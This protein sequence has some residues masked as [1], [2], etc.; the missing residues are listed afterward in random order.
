MP[1]IR[2]HFRSVYKNSVSELLRSTRC[3]LHQ[4]DVTYIIYQLIPE[5]NHKRLDLI[6]LPGQRGSY[7]LPS[8]S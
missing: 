6:A 7:W 3:S 2:N 1:Y 4:W 8:K 5:N